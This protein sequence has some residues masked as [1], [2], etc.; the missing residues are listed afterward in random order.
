MKVGARWLYICRLGTVAGQEIYVSFIFDYKRLILKFMRK[1]YATI[2]SAMVRQT[3]NYCVDQGLNNEYSKEVFGDD[4]L[5]VHYP[6]GRIESKK[7]AHYY[8]IAA[9]ELEDPLIGV[10]VGHTLL[11]NIL[12]L[13]GDAAFSAPSVGHAVDTIQRYIAL[14]TE[15]LV[16]EISTDIYGVSIFVRPFNEEAVS[17]HQI[18]GLIT[19]CVKYLGMSVV[20]FDGVVVRLK[21]DRTQYAQEYRFYLKA[22]IKFGCSDYEIRL[23]ARLIQQRI[24]SRDNERHIESISEVERSLKRL[25]SNASKTDLLKNY[26]GE[27]SLKEQS[28]VHAAAT[29]LNL[30]VRKLQRELKQ[31]GSSFTKLLDEHKKDV[32][33]KLLTDDNQ[34]ASTIAESLGFYDDSAFYKAFKRWTGFTPQQFI[35]RTNR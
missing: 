18:E 35:E 2:S 6:E 4:M 8:E 12:G 14:L 21:H 31:E 11:P 25:Q 5:R 16:I 1:T 34:A 29:F 19:T 20:Q 13:I 23:P 22:D 33:I 26:F 27:T 24:V 9:R 3:I 10:K 15:A 28:D 32:A 7:L 30:S 17:Y